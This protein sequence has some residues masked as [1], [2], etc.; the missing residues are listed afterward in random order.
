MRVWPVTNG[1]A[2]G[3]GTPSGVPAPDRMTGTR[4]SWRCRLGWHDWRCQIVSGTRVDGVCRRCGLRE[5][6]R[7]S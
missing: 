6:W 2:S 3:E 5:P 7:W 1:A 4:V